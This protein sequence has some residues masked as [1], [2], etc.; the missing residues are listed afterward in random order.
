M[1]NAG[2]SGV[3]EDTVKMRETLWQLIAETFNPDTPVHEERDEHDE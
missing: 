2:M 3:D 1:L